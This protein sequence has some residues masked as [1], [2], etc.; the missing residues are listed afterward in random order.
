MFL[1]LFFGLIIG[2]GLII[3][4]FINYSSNNQI[5]PDLDY[6]DMEDEKT[7]NKTFILDLPVEKKLRNAIFEC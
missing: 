6:E 2:L 7:L 5:I 1:G 3:Y 4:L